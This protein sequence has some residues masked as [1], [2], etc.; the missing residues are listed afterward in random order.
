MAFTKF[1]GSSQPVWLLPLLLIVVGI[2]CGL[3]LAR[4]ALRAAEAIVSADGAAILIEAATWRAF[5]NTLIT[6]LAGTLISVILGLAFALAIALTDIRARAA[7]VLAFML[8]MMIPP[9]ITALAWIQMSGPASPLLKLVGLAPPLGS[10]QPLYSLSGI[11]L[12]LGVQNAPLVFLAV[13]VGLAAIPRDLV[14]A[15]RLSGAR[16]RTVL[17]SVILPLAVPGLVAGAAI[18]FV[19]AVGNFG[20]PAMLGLPA[21]IVTL[22]TLVYIRLASFGI[23][24]LGDMALL[25]LLIAALAI[26]GILLQNRAMGAR[27]YRT[28]GLAAAGVE[29]R[30]GAWQLPVELALWG[31]LGLILLAPALA[32]VASSL[33]PT[34]GVAL[35]AETASL[36]AYEAVLSGQ[37][38]T[39][40]AFRNSF[41]LAGLAAVILLVVT[42][43]LGWWMARSRSALATFVAS[44]IEVP[45]ALPGIIVAVACILL[46]AAPL[47]GIGISIYGTLWIILFAYLASFMAVSLKPMISAFAQTDPSLDEAASLSGARY[48]RRMRDIAL[49]LAAPAAGAAAILVFLIAVNELTISTLLWSAGTQTLGVAVFNLDDSGE[50]NLASALSVLIV[51]MIF[52]LMLALDRL[53][54]RLPRGAVPWRV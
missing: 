32:L 6:S 53:A 17:S 41:L 1:R 54:V 52:I 25:S 48:L 26:G 23:D 34:Y 24:T 16:Q 37:P 31:I 4:L 3:P 21:S 22:P 9:Q 45:Y 51:L 36:A 13:R 19:S 15:A 42:L 33:V 39:I 5:R 20:I 18:A 12:L 43:P 35:N 10:P 46:F 44:F 40:A 8:P 2:F 14:E 27:D 28:I 50:A 30:L 29:F 38:L 11:S 49:P 47:P 7:L